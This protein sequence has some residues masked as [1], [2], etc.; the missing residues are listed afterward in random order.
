MRRRDHGDILKL[1]PPQASEGFL[2]AIDEVILFSHPV[3]AKLGTH[4]IWKAATDTADGFET[5]Y[6]NPSKPQSLQPLAILQSDPFWFLTI[7]LRRRHKWREEVKMWESRDD[8]RKKSHS[9]WHR[10]ILYEEIVKV[11][12]YTETFLFKVCSRRQ[13]LM[14]LL[15]TQMVEAEHCRHLRPTDTPACSHGHNHHGYHL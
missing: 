13:M 8:N 14:K 6:V 7:G 1:I 2:C 9:Q 12:T 10:T 15:G 3:F 5:V 11:K 4:H